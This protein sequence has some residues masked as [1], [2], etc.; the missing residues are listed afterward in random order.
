MKMTAAAEIDE[1]MAAIWLVERPLPLSSSLVGAAV[2]D[3]DAEAEAEE[4]EEDVEEVG[5]EVDEDVDEGLDDVFE[6]VEE[7]LVEVERV[8]DVLDEVGEVVGLLLDIDESNGVGT[9]LGHCVTGTA[10]VWD[11]VMP[12]RNLPSTMG[13]S[14]P[15]TQP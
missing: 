13:W 10:I 14:P 2:E 5:D 12:S 4:E 15:L 8:E 6:E 9:L 1:A 11:G 3:D 7:D